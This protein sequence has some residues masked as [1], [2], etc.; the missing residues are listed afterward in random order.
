MIT[1]KEFIEF[2]LFEATLQS[3]LKKALKPAGTIESV[4]G[5]EAD[6][7]AAILRVQPSEKVYAVD[8]S[9]DVYK[10]VLGSARPHTAK[11]GSDSETL[12][13][14]KFIGNRKAIVFGNKIITDEFTFKSLVD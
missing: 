12:S 2:P 4:F 9:S 5:D 14:V 1:F 3:L 7:A 8:D 6:E 11:N 13:V 10:K